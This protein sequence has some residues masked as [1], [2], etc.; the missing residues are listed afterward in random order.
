MSLIQEI[1]DRLSGVSALREHVR[2]LRESMR[3][4]HRVILDH[5][6]RIARLEA[7]PPTSSKRGLSK[8]S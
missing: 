2:D 4:Q 6:G 7:A 8:P 1:F 3:E 5:E